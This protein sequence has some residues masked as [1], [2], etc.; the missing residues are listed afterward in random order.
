MTSHSGDVALNGAI[1]S[2]L[3]NIRV[4]LFSIHSDDGNLPVST[5]N[6]TAVV[7]QQ[8]HLAELPQI[9]F[10]LTVPVFKQ[11]DDSIDAIYKMMSFMSTVVTSCFPSTNNQLI[12]SSNPRQQATIRDRREE[13]E[14]LADLGIA[15]G[16]VTQSVITHN[17][18]YQVDDLDAFDTE[19][20][21]E[22]KVKELENIVSLGFQNPFSLKKAQQN[23]PMLYDGNV[24]AK[25]TNVISIADSKETLMLE[26]ESRSKCLDIIFV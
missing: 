6:S 5:S 24:I 16:P 2:S 20:A 22:K 26:E 10:G 15:E 19:I 17:A 14:F 4:I 1:C 25:E 23:R 7:N 9:D 18:A 11:G 3:R 21:L 13:L 12:N 8:T